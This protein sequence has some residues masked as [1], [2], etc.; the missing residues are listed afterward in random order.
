MEPDKSDEGSRVRNNYVSL[1]EYKV[2][3]S[4]EVEEFFS[5]RIGQDEFSKI[6][7]LEC[8]APPYLILCAFS[9]SRYTSIRVNIL[10]TSGE[11]AVRNVN[12]C[13]GLVGESE[14]LADSF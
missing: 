2:G 14:K 9:P 13:N 8:Q 4:A 12:I 3:F 1:D 10:S 7:K 11:E 6:C 5:Q